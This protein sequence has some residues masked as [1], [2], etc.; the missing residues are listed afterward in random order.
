ME[1]EKLNTIVLNLYP[2]NKGYSL[3][4]YQDD[5]QIEA[6]NDSAV[7]SAS[8][9]NDCISSS[10]ILGDGGGGP[11]GGGG[12]GGALFEGSGGLASNVGSSTALTGNSGVK[13]GTNGASSSRLKQT[14]ISNNSLNNKNS[15]NLLSSKAD[16]V[17][18]DIILGGGGDNL[19]ST[20]IFDNYN[21][22]ATTLNAEDN[23]FVQSSSTTA[24]SVDNN[25]DK[26]DDDNLV[27]VMSW[28]Y[29]VDDLLNSIDKEELPIFISDLLETRIPNVFYS[30]C[31]ICQVRDYRQ[32]F[33]ISSN[34]CDIYHVLLKPTNEVLYSDINQLSIDSDISSDDKLILES[35]LILATSE[36][37]CLDPDPKIG[38]HAIN[39]QHRK[40]MWNTSPLRRQMKKYSQISINRKRKIDQFT[41]HYGLELCDYLQRLRQRPRP[42][43]TVPIGVAGASRNATNSNTTTH[44]LASISKL[45]KKPS[46][47]LRPIRA[48][49]LDYPP[50]S[51]PGT[52]DVLSLA[53]A[54]PH[55]NREAK[56][57]FLPVLIEEY[58]LE[59]DRENGHV[60]LIKLSIYQRPA[61][62]EYLG[63]LYVDRYIRMRFVLVAE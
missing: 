56:E 12:G 3:A 28:P 54:Y 10:T 36:P 29:E 18:L 41:H 45:Q 2:G 49:N 55:K 42:L 37:L 15:N 43:P 23:M 16:I 62:A 4:F 58:T 44:M 57:D 51:D 9:S 22:N 8:A 14:Q 32:T 5:N 59:S 30:G 50:L 19:K 24:A 48:P 1:R 47:I 60:Y 11:G 61:T 33:P 35:Q 25:P 21:M 34:S 63:E 26:D 6:L 40:Q 53:K 27:E 46:E 20:N 7:N 39:S 52:V 38:R 13:H 17:D 31:V